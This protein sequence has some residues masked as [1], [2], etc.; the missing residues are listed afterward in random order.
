MMMVLLLK[1]MELV[2]V[3][4]RLVVRWG[5]GWVMVMDIYLIIGR[6]FVLGGGLWLCF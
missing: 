4:S 1:V 5:W 6:L 3:S 2:L